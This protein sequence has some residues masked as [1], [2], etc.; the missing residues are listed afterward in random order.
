V[1]ALLAGATSPAPPT[2]E[3]LV[4]EVPWDQAPA[5]L[6]E[7]LSLLPRA[8]LYLQDEVQLAL[9]PTL[10][11]LWCRRGRAGQRRVE[12]P[13]DNRK[14]YGFGLVD[15]R[16]GWFDYQLAPARTAAP[17]CEQLAR[18]VARSQARGRVAI[19]I[20]DNLGTHTPQGSL[21]VRQLLAA[22]QG[23]LYLVYTPAYDPEANPIEWLWRV[24]RRA[25]THNHQRREMGSLLADAEGHFQGL[26]A[27]PAAV[28][29]HISSPGVASH[30]LALPLKAAA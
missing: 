22:C 10:T 14:L 8:D 17:F 26:Q 21:L 19:V 20:A 27:D 29:R 7:L 24:T 18:A 30:S 16:E 25:V 15:W 3:A 9:H 28:L 23:A 4:P 2:L 6:P 13:G 12:A 1:A 5:D 11:R